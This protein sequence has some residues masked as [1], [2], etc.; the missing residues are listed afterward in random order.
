MRVT[1]GVFYGKGAEKVV[2]R[3]AEGIELSLNAASLRAAV[4]AAR[5]N[6]ANALALAVE[7]TNQGDTLVAV[8][9]STYAKCYAEDINLKLEDFPV[10]QL[11]L[12]WST[13]LT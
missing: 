13:A 12:T 9:A 10:L 8:E 2:K 7:A 5:T 11:D 1:S 6:I 4:S 3:A